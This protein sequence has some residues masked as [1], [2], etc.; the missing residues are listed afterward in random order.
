MIRS[1][2]TVS[3]VPELRGGPFIFWDDLAAVVRK[4]PLSASMPSNCFITK[5]AP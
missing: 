3:L 2:V 4:P 5:R 1:A